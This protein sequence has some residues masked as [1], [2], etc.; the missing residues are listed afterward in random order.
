MSIRV[1][2]AIREFYPT[3]RFSMST[4]DDYEHLTWLSEDIPKPTKEELLETVEQFRVERPLKE[5]R[6]ER[7]TL[8]TQTDKIYLPTTTLA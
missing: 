5:L 3:A 8:P 1:S 6:K 4:D 7:D 2:D